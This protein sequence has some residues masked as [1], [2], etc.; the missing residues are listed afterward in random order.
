M[1]SHEITI[2]GEKFS[3]KSDGDLEYVANLAKDIQNRYD[4]V[5]NNKPPR[6]AVTAQAFRSMAIVAIG[7]LDELNQVQK[8]KNQLSSESRTFANE[9]SARID[10]ILS[11]S[12]TL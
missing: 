7:L 3:L 12:F 5:N 4:T 6:S 2:G 8:S 11:E 1:Q 9:M 10:Q